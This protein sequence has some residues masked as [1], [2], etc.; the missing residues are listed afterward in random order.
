MRK[1]TAVDL[2]AG[3]G[4]LTT[5]LK[6][7][8]FSV[9]AAV[10]IDPLASKTYK[11]NH[12][13]VRIWRRNITQV[14]ASD[15]SRRSRLLP[16]SLDLLAGC[17]PCQAFSTMRT[18]NRQ[19]RIRDP[20]QKDL[21]HQLVRF[22]RVLKPKAIM[23]ENVP[24]L[25]RDRR[26]HRFISALNNLGYEC[27]YKVLDCADYAV[28]QR[29]RR[30]ILLG[31]RIGP[32]R[33]ARPSRTRIPIG[34]VLR[35][36]GRPGTSGDELHDLPENRSAAVQRRIRMIPKN[37]GS[38]SDLGL[39][40]QLRCHRKCNGFKDVYGRMQWNAVAP[41]ITTGC[42]NPSKGRFLH[43]RANRAITLREAAMLQTFPKRYFFDLSA[44]KCA[45]AS[46]IGNA[47]PPEFIRRQA[48]S[49]RKHLLTR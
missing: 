28:P 42:Y 1:P 27:E 20:R 14:V 33:F 46:M 19:R 47:L 25:A 2:F 36:L 29:R 39:G 32:V 17:P 15:L 13:E 45:A 4:G 5:G 10:E 6:K 22:A 8:G 7:A 40:E 16:G 21:L 23:V 34:R 30:L 44:G 12:P 18:L 41:T 9:V 43:P 49:V 11:R 35:N 38:R 3:C 37:G 31:S 26:W 24:D 48:L